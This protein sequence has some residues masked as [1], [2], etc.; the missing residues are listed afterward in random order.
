MLGNDI[1]DDVLSQPGAFAPF[2][3]PPQYNQEEL[4]WDKSSSSI[5]HW[6]F[7]LP[8]LPQNHV[9]TEQDGS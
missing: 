5:W 6:G 8:L 3:T 4:Y 7:V 9:S 1:L 2:R